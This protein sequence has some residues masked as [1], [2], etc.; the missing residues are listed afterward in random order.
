MKSENFYE[1]KRCKMDWLDDI[2]YGTKSSQGTRNAI[3]AIKFVLFDDISVIPDGLEIGDKYEF[4]SSRKDGRAKAKML[5]KIDLDQILCKYAMQSFGIKNI[6]FNI[7]YDEYN[8]LRK[9][10]LINKKYTMD[11][12]VELMAFALTDSTYGGYLFLNSNKFIKNILLDSLI[13]E[14]YIEEKYQELDSFTGILDNINISDDI[15]KSYLENFNKLDDDFLNIKRRDN[16]YL[17][18]IGE[19]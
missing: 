6:P 4:I 7:T 12:A 13:N 15:K 17:N 16:S 9:K 10:H 5:Q 1:M 8:S 14:R 2:Y 3:N 19:N 18:Y 11:Y